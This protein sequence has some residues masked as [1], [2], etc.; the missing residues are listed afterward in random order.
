MR[1][2]GRACLA[3]L[4]LTWRTRRLSR[5]CSLAPTST[6]GRGG[7]RFCDLFRGFERSLAPTMRQEH[8]AGDK[9]F[10]DYSGKRLAI[11]D[12]AT[13]EIREAEIFVGVLGA[14]G[15]TYAQ[16]TWTQTLYVSSLPWW[17]REPCRRDRFIE[18][19]DV[20]TILPQIGIEHIVTCSAAG[21]A[22]PRLPLS[23]LISKA[24][25]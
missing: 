23:S 18:L 15:L 11:V 17:H 10:V 13:G 8:V 7:C 6:K 19:P 21:R 4:P 16:A 1:H 25:S 22:G 12:P 5:G 14:S 2:S 3:A 20:D 9:A 24:F